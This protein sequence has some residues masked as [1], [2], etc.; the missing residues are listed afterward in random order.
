MTL[1]P[2]TTPFPSCLHFGLNRPFCLALLHVDL[3]PE[4]YNRLLKEIREIFKDIQF[5]FASEH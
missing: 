1:S 4:F 5:K 2:M 3:Y